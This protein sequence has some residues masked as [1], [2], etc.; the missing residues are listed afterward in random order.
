MLGKASNL[1]ENFN[2]YEQ[3]EDKFD[4]NNKNDEDM[5]EF[6]KSSNSALSDYNFL[7]D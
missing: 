6:L 5:E 3:E 7:F 2:E 4:G 1:S